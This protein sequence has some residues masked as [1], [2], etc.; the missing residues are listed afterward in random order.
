MDS[1]LLAAANRVS[2]QGQMRDGLYNAYLQL[3][4]LIVCYHLLDLD[5]CS[6]PLY[7]R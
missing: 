2:T 5:Q 7:D 1:A 4:A 3:Q 6:I